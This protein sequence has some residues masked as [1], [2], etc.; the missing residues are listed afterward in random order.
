MLVLALAGAAMAFTADR[1][2]GYVDFGG[3]A[4]VGP[5]PALAVGF[6]IWRGR[7]DDELSFGR[8]WSAG[9]GV[10][11]APGLD[12]V[13]TVWSLEVRHG[14]DLIVAGLH[15]FAAAGPVLVQREDRE[16]GLAARVGGAAEFRRDA[17]LG[18]A[19]RLEAGVDAIGGVVSPAGMVT[20]GVQTVFARELR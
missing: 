11:Q 3:G 17:T 18:L 2:G 9:L 12:S 5:A 14:M 15:G 19:L 10:A 1:L 4:A 13:R 20:V 6:G 16:L 7:Y 8:F